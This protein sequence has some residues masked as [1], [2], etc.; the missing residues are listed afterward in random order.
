MAS[1]LDRQLQYSV[2]K[3]L[4]FRQ[5][6]RDALQTPLAFNVLHDAVSHFNALRMRPTA[7]SLIE[8]AHFRLTA[9]RMHL[10]KNVDS[11]RD[12]ERISN[13][14]SAALEVGYLLRLATS[15]RHSESRV[16]YVSRA[17]FYL[18]T[19]TLTEAS[20]IIPAIITGHA[21]PGLPSSRNVTPLP[22]GALVYLHAVILTGDERTITASV[23]IYF[24]RYWYGVVA[25]DF[26]LNTM[27]RLLAEATDDR[28]EGSISCTTPGSI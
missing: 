26:S 6:M 15:S 9:S 17:G 2:D 20:D 16:I 25:M 5:S 27:Q 14:I 18:S 24:N 10:L 4:L 12:A 21:V 19:D 8:I 1:S 23:P 7:A 13:E 28:T 3:M 22:R 11:E